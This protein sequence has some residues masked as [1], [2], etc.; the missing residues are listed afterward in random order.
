MKLPQCPS[1]KRKAK[2]AA[3]GDF[4][5]GG[6]VGT[7]CTLRIFVIPVIFNFLLSFFV[8]STLVLHG[9]RISLSDHYLLDFH[10]HLEFLS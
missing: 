7:T 6:A 8:L 3:L 2:D 1:K 9:L 4:E 10:S 5:K